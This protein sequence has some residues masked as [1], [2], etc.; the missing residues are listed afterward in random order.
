[1]ANKSVTSG[2]A[3]SDRLM[4]IY[5]KDHLAAAN[6]ALQVAKRCLANNPEDPLGASLGR[7][8]GDLEDDRATVERILR[9]LGGA[10]DRV[11]NVAVWLAERSGRLKLNGSI[12]GYSDLSRL[13]ELEC[14]R[15]LLDFH[16]SL[17]RSL[18]GLRDERLEGYDFT[19]L[20]SRAGD[21]MGALEDHLDAAAALALRPG[22][23]VE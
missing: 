9:M 7:L 6:L 8:V 23:T 20:L 10:P 3:M 2:T 14:L 22:P 12:L 15:M 13:E 17:W 5:L 18:G 21:H 4:L 16:R 11:K 1:M 19:L